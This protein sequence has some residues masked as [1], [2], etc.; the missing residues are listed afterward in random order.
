MK[1]N[2]DL[3]FYVL[4]FY[5]I[6][7]HQ[8]ILKKNIICLEIY[9]LKLTNKYFN[10]LIIEY[11]SHF[12]NYKNIMT[13]NNI[14]IV[15][16]LYWNEIGIIGNQNMFYEIK[17]FKI[18]ENYNNIIM[19]VCFYNNKQILLWIK[20]NNSHLFNK[21][22]LIYWTCKTG[23]IEILDWLKSINFDFNPFIKIGLKIEL[24]NEKYNIIKWFKLK[25]NY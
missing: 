1:L 16:T 15:K 14:N 11:L 9:F 3:F 5:N 2:K 21:N 10:N 18:I 17:N 23:N 13:E 4:S 12:Y 6:F 8:H 7:I 24:Q 25:I 20:N 19:N 22:I